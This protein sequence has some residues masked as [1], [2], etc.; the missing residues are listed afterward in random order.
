MF[1]IRRRLPEPCS[2][3]DLRSGISIVAPADEPLLEMFKEVCVDRCYAP[4][5]F[6]VPA[7]HA[8]IDVGANVGVF[9]LWA[10]TR[11]PLARVITP[12]L[13]R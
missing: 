2:R 7:G 5:D 11:W 8:I 13:H 1:P 12:N 10:A 3:I 6:Q 9:T 4:T